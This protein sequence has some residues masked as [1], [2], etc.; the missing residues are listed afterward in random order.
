MTRQMELIETWRKAASNYTDRASARLRL[1]AQELAAV[2]T[3]EEAEGDEDVCDWHGQRQREHS[4]VDCDGGGRRCIHCKREEPTAAAAVPAGGDAEVLE[5]YAQSYE[6]MAAIGDGRVRCANVALDIRQN[7]IPQM[8][9][10]PAPRGGVT[11]ASQKELVTRI[12][13]AIREWD[14]RGKD[15]IEAVLQTTPPAAQAQD[16]GPMAIDAMIDDL[17]KECYT[18]GWNDCLAAKEAK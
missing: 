7:I 8:S 14:G 18:K 10:A 2:L 11:E 13:D 1:C 17:R 16:A 4:W 3:Q 12:W 9:N 15:P 6:R 5:M